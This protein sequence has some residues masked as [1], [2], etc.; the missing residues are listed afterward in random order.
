MKKDIFQKQRDAVVSEFQ[1]R[2]KKLQE[3]GVPGMKWGERNLPTRQS[4]YGKEKPKP[5]GSDSKSAKARRLAHQGKMLYGLAANAS[6]AAGN[7]KT[8]LGKSRLLAL[9]KA[10]RK[11]MARINKATDVWTDK[12]SWD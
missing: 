3:Y 5:G 6:A 4:T 8:S 9:A 7:A 12:H 2:E 1:S 11:N 10:S